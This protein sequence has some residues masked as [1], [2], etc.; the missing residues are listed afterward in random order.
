VVLTETLYS[1]SSTAGDTTP[2]KAAHARFFE[3]QSDG[4]VDE[5]GAIDLTALAS[6]VDGAHWI[7]ADVR[8]SS[9]DEAVGLRRDGGL[10]IVQLDGACTGAACI[11]ILAPPAELADPTGFRAVDA[12]DDGDLDL[13][14]IMRNR[15]LTG[16]RGSQ[17]Y[18]WWNDGGFAPARTQA[19][20]GDGSVV[21][22]GFV[23]LDRDGV[24]ELV[25][26]EQGG[27]GPGLRYAPLESGLYQALVPLA[28]AADGVALQTADVNGDGLGDLVV[29]SGVERTA[30]RELSIY[31]QS[32]NRISAGA[33]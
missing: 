27:S 13:L 10:V 3:G 16:G 4:Q 6:G 31:T 32:E 33:E 12:D 8:G 19:V 20:S 15:G 23:D 28:D 9:L 29:V 14:A 24:H 7:G 30:P 21:D 11:T 18:L 25:V 22:A 2:L 26:L 1:P 17:V 5:S